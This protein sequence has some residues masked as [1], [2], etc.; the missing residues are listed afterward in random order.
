MTVSSVTTVTDGSGIGGNTAGYV[1]S[2]AF[3]LAFGLAV[4]SQ[5]NQSMLDRYERETSR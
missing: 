3:A 1:S 5:S 2:P 4:G